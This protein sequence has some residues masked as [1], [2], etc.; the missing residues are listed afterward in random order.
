METPV[1]H[2][3]VKA[4][5]KAKPNPTPMRL[6][7]AA[8]GIAGASALLSAIVLPPHQPLVTQAQP[9]TVYVEQ[10]VNYIYLKPGQTAPPGATVIKAGSTTLPGVSAGN[11]SQPLVVTVAPPAQTAPKPV[12]K[13]SQSGKVLP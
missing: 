9:T 7:W 2:P 11:A 4:S 13:T 1:V 12:V 3:P 6:A 10:P 8:A 5:P